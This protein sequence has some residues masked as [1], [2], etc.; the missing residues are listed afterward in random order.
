[1][2]TAKQGLTLFMRSKIMTPFENHLSAALLF[3]VGDDIAN[4]P[5]SQKSHSSQSCQEI[6][7]AI[8]GSQF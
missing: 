4:Q 2:N 1:M 5:P 7:M 6:R 3:L 8:F